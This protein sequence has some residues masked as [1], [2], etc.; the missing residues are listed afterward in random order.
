MQVT[1]SEVHL[2]YR[3][4]YYNS[5]QVSDTLICMFGEMDTFKAYK[6]SRST[7]QFW[8][9]EWNF[10]RTVKVTFFKEYKERNS[11]LQFWPSECA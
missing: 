8:P 6:V 3:A 9:G 7:L 11:T 5:D 2:G 10:I 1:F 4:L